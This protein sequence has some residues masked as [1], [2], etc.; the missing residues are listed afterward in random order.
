MGKRFLLRL[1]RRFTQLRSYRR[2]SGT[3]Y[4]AILPFLYL[5]VGRSL[6]VFPEGHNKLPYSFWIIN[7]NFLPR[8][9]AGATHGLLY[10]E[11]PA[12]RRNSE[13]VTSKVAKG[14]VALNMLI[15]AP[16]GEG[17]PD[18]EKSLS[19]TRERATCTLSGTIVSVTPSAT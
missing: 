12:L 6:A 8:L 15:L 11:L 5:K 16:P 17:A 13:S 14:H 7:P 9:P 1:G 19:N 18:T 2:T 3:D 4:L 10:D